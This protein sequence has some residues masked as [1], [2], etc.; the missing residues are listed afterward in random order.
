MSIIKNTKNKKKSIFL[1][2][3]VVCLE[4]LILIYHQ[5]GVDCVTFQ[6]IFHIEYVLIMKGNGKLSESN[7]S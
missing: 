1:C 4:Y 2:L 6:I 5:Y 7:H 3:C